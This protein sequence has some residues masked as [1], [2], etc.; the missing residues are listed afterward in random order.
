[1]SMIIIIQECE[2]GRVRVED[3]ANA[4]PLAL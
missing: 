3:A 1:M 2:V 4:R